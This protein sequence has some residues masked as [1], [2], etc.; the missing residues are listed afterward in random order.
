[1]LWWILG[2]IVLNIILLLF[3]FFKIKN[4]FDKINFVNKNNDDLRREIFQTIQTF[5]ESILN[6]LHEN[7][8]IQTNQ[9]TVFAK[10]FETMT[11][12]N[13]TKLENIRKVIDVNLT[14]LRKDNEQKLEKM[15]QTVDEKLHNTLEQRLGTSF[16]LVNDQ[17]ETVYKGLGEMRGLAASVGDLKKVLNNVKT[18]G[19][20][21]EV[22][23]GNLLDQIFTKD[24]YSENVA[25]IK[26]SSNRVEFAIK[27]PNRGVDDNSFIWLPI[28][29]KFPQEDYYRIV[30]CEESSD[31]LGL[32]SA[33]KDLEIRIEQEAKK[34]RDKYVSPPETTDFA[35]MFLPVE[36]LY[37]EVLKKRALCETLY[38][39]YRIVV[40]GPTTLAAILS[41]LQVGFRTLAI[42]KRSSEVW[43]LLDT[44]K[45]EFSNFGRL[46]DKTKK[47]LQE[48]QNSID[49][50]SQKSRGIEKKLGKVE[51]LNYN[52]GEEEDIENIKFE[53]DLL[54]IDNN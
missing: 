53:K 2:I 12:I 27:L 28:D 22:Q 34:I 26:D 50:A 21:G 13:E 32:E 40:A 9:L 46:L 1:M 4:F 38:S 37:A 45:N 24:Q 41:S 11:N 15:R 49:T 39:K 19:T 51:S 25:T 18:R 3:L 48:A 7:N 16:K 33:G 36:G 47:K 52:D 5:N 10:Q 14:E 31:Y 44:I 20:L 43:K 8:L 6:R 17:L 42:E 23:L 29:A 35:I 30:E 54:D